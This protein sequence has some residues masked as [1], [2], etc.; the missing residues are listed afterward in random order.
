MR[1]LLVHLPHLLPP[2]LA[3]A[4]LARL[5]V[6]AADQPPQHYSDDEVEEWRVARLALHAERRRPVRRST[7]LAGLLALVPLL[8]AFGTGLAIYTFNLRSDRPSGALT[9]VHTISASIGLVVV[10]VKVARIG[11]ARI[12]SSLSLRRPQQAFSSLVLLVLGLPLAGTG[13]AELLAPNGHSFAD[14]VH[15]ISSVWWTILLQ[16]HL[17]R[18]LGRALAT[19]LRSGRPRLEPGPSA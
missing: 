15:L 14:Y 18:Y 11:R 19:S 17:W 5:G 8:V 3:F 10:A 9:W 16:W 1:W 12:G 7:A 6:W 4:L 2:V 13:V